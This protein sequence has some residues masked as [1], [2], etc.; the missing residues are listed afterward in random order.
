M[1]GST[2]HTLQIQRNQ[3]GNAHEDKTTTVY[4]VNNIWNLLPWARTDRSNKRYLTCFVMVTFTKSSITQNLRHLYYALAILCHALR[5]MAKFYW[6][7]FIRTCFHSTSPSCK[8]TEQHRRPWMTAGTSMY[9]CGM[10]SDKLKS[11][12]SPSSRWW[13]FRYHLSGARNRKHHCSLIQ[14]SLWRWQAI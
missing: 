13:N 11:H 10:C 5:A 1:P 14:H 12:C 8:S 2:S 4:K 7:A 9:S 3:Q 6:V